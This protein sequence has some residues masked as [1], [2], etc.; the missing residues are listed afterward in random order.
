MTEPSGE[1]DEHDD[2]D[3]DVFRWPTSF[4]GI[5][6]PLA[7][8]RNGKQR[9]DEF[10]RFA[11]A[12][13]DGRT[14]AEA[15]PEL[16]DTHQQAETRKSM[17][18]EMGLLYVPKASNRV[19]LTPVG[20]QL[21]E[22]LSSGDFTDDEVA[23][24]R[25]NAVIAWALS[26][27]QI[28]RPQ[29]RGSPSP[30]AVQWQTC[31]IR[32]YAAGWQALLELEGSLSIDEFFGS[33]WFV[34]SVDE[35]WPAI[36]SI[37]RARVT[38]SRFVDESRLQDG[39]DLMNPRI[40]WT[41]HL[42]SGGT[43]LTLQR[44]GRFVFAPRARELV[45]TVLRFAGG[46]SSGGEEVPFRARPYGSLEQY[47]DEIAGRACPEFLYSGFLRVEKVDQQPITVLEG[48]RTQVRGEEVILE[49]GPE[50]CSI[51][52]NTPC[53][54]ESVPDRLL[55]LAVKEETTDY[56]VILKL[57]KARPFFGTF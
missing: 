26:N 42:S 15:K 17:L 21:Y 31:D 54:H 8:G 23:Q 24:R 29:S 48:Y 5:V 30:K 27:S 12:V 13:L 20:H 1:R 43:I 52:I 41:S 11:T 40:Y 4:V 7:E 53:Y 19:I 16:S 32:P 2:A 57:Q 37:R 35:F 3:G 33:L 6:H 22:L 38:S 46:C 44:D 55:R 49:G 45:T 36:D 28:N 39:G 47:F 50:L 18:E 10:V 25:I 56:K 34:H 51:P 9:A 14:Y